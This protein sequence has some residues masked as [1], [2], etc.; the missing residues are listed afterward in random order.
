[1]GFLKADDAKVGFLPSM[2]GPDNIMC[3]IGAVS[4]KFSGTL[5]DSFAPLR[6][7]RQG[8]P[9]SPFLFLFVADGLSSILKNKV[10]A[11]EWS[12]YSDY[13]V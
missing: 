9:L 5:L 7:L 3:H 10:S 8:E 12:Y 1:M 2:G 13:G 4:V 6:G 11:S